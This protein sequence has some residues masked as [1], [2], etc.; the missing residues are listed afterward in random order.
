[1]ALD[2][3]NVATPVIAVLALLV[4]LALLVVHYRN[5]SERRH[6]EIVLLRVQIIA[7]LSSLQQRIKSIHANA[8]I[9]RI[10]AR[11]LPD[12]PAKWQT[13]EKLPEIIADTK[14]ISDDIDKI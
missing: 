13:I 2:L 9:V 1:M 8:E 4:S 14:G 11:R 5:Q 6:G 12:S 7:E 10:E 3:M